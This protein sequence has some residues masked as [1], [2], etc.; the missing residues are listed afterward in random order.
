ML[1]NEPYC[2]VLPKPYCKV[3]PNS[4]EK[5]VTLYFSLPITITCT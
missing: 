5:W 2:K 3:L 4:E 1:T